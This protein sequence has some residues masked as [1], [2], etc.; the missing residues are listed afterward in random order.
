MKRKYLIIALL[1][2][3]FFIN[4]NVFAS[5]ALDYV[6]FN[7]PNSEKLKN[8]DN[9]FVSNFY[10]PDSTTRLDLQFFYSQYVKKYDNSFCFSVNCFVSIFFSFS[11]Y[12][13]LYFF[14]IFVYNTIKKQIL[15]WFNIKK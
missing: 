8:I 2:S 6:K 5:E 11:I 3:L 14:V 1:F 13:P 15:Q 4:K 9:K 10:F 12:I 7:V